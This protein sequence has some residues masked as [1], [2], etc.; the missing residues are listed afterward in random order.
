M[1]G[2]VIITHGNLGS[3][4]LEV[5]SKIMGRKFHIPVI[6]IDWEEGGSLIERKAQEIKR[7]IEKENR[8]HGVVVFTDIFGGTP[9]NLCVSLLKSLDVEIITGLNLPL[10]LK[11]LSERDKMSIEDLSRTLVKRGK[12]SI[13]R[14][15]E[16]LD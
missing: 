10:L 9:T 7:A 11:F 6:S 14:I 12:E 13:G 15:R 1:I 3:T 16:F 8:G 2:G 5:A 4:L